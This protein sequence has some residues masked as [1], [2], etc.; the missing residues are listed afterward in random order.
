[1]RRQSEQALGA[2]RKAA[3]DAQQA[4]A[5]EAKVARE[6]R[7]ALEE[8]RSQQKATEEELHLVNGTMLRQYA[9]QEAQD[10]VAKQLRQL[11]QEDQEKLLRS[12]SERAQLKQQVDALE[13]RLKVVMASQ[14][15]AAEDFGKQR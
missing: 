3:T 10:E 12:A 7:E 15:K 6:A 1:M 9:E 4:I 13:E 11:R 5:V 14:E 8:A 2:A